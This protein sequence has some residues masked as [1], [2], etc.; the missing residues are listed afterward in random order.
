MHFDIPL[1]QAAFT[2][3]NIDLVSVVRGRDYRHSYRSGREKHGFIYLIQGAMTGEFADSTVGQIH[4]KVGQLLF[5]PKGTEYVSVYNEDDTRIRIIQFDLLS[6]RLPMY[7][8]RP[9]RLELPQSRELL[10]GLFAP[11]DPNGTMH[12][13]YCLS[14]LY[15]LLWQ[16]DR[17]HSDIPPKYKRLKNALQ[18]MSEGFDRDSSVDEYAA[19][20][21]M[22][23]VTFRRLFKEYTGRAPIEYRNDLRL[24]SARAKLQSGE[25][26]VTEAAEACGFHSLSFFIRLYKKK[27]GYTPKK[28]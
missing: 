27:Y 28:E 12:P 23:N 22:S 6:G 14:G 10:K 3:G 24:S 4:L 19:L 25:Y 11:N 5:V 26:N 13:F 2:V 16:I 8:S 20:C 17:L 18:A 7:L 1:N 15:G 9:V 21:D